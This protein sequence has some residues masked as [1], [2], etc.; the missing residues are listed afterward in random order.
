LT[1]VF[2]LQF[3]LVTVQ[4]AVSDRFVSSMSLVVQGD[5]EQ[6]C[7]VTRTL[8]T[9]QS[10]RPSHPLPRPDATTLSRT[11]PSCTT[12]FA[13]AIPTWPSWAPKPHTGSLRTGGEQAGV[14]RPPSVIVF[15]LVH[16]SYV[17]TIEIFTAL[18][19]PGSSCVPQARRPDPPINVPTIATTNAD[20]RLPFNVI[21]FPL[22]RR[23]YARW[24]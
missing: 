24:S 8:M 15:G 21:W 23:A 2:S 11:S 5:S 10:L 19:R 13:L 17:V 6:R 7:V 9:P 1:V 4:H 3:P 14:G 16:G 20:T 22:G 12:P 18:P